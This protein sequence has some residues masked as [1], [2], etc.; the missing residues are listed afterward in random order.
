MNREREEWTPALG[1]TS[2]DPADDVK[3][4]QVIRA[5]VVVPWSRRRR[6][7]EPPSS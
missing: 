6:A 7:L 5:I 1:H 4:H 2:D 3:E